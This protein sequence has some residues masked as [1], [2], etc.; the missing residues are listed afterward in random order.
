MSYIYSTKYARKRD[1]TF[2]IC[3]ARAIYCE[4]YLSD[5]KREAAIGGQCELTDVIPETQLWAFRAAEL[6]ECK[7]REMH[8]DDIIGQWTEQMEASDHR[9]GDED[10]D[11][12]VGWYAAMEAMGHGVG[13]SDYGIE[14]QLP[15]LEAHEM[16][17][18]WYSAELK[19]Y[20]QRAQARR[21]RAMTV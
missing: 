10:P 13:L 3:A 7:C 9:Q 1:S 5:E 14:T 15:Y 12:M 17:G 21:K 11:E 6:F 18:W 8:G 2:V 4:W 19:N 20:Q 16:Q